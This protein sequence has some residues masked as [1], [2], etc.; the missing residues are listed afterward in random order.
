MVGMINGILNFNFKSKSIQEQTDK[1]L[2]EYGI[3]FVEQTF[4]Q[5]MQGGKP[6]KYKFKKRLNQDTKNE[7]NLKLKKLKIKDNKN[8]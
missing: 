5:F 8:E 2:A 7:I 3:S 6:D 4:E 1:L